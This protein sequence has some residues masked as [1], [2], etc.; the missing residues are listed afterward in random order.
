MLN[1][2][3]GG[4]SGLNWP[5][6]IWHVMTD[7]LHAT[8]WPVYKLS[9]VGTLTER[10][11]KLPEEPPL[12]AVFCSNVFGHYMLAHNLM[13][14]L[15]RSGKPNGPGRV[16]WISSVEPTKDDFDVHDIQGF[17]APAAYNSSKVL[18]DLLSLT[19]DLPSTAPWAN[20]FLS[21]SDSDASIPPSDVTAEP[22]DG[23]TPKI[24]LCQPG[25]FGTGIVPLPFILFWTMIGSFFFA[26]WL[27]SP[28]HTIWAYTAACAPVWLALSPQSVLDE[29]EEPYRRHGGGLVKW[30]SSTDR[31]GRERPVCTEV[32]GWGYGGVV[33]AAI[34]E[35]DARRR[36][37]RGV[38]DATA[39]EKIHFEECGRRCWQ[40][41]EQLRI[42]W[43][44]LLD[45]DEAAAEQLQN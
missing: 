11:T 27:G 16:I 12:G 32:D 25:I 22:R 38:K 43:E 17:K 45:K 2:G 36:R 37:K 23:P 30:G 20:S 18:T 1:A 8:T 29:A 44:K 41:M 33:G 7:L 13:P 31:L 5:Q 34:L 14:L 3:I 24:Y 35:E 6:A 42:Q 40:E 10:Q 9:V 4:W 19:S 26:R 15:R 28:W 39:E 21:I